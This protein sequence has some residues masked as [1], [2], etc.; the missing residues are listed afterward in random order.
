MFKWCRRFLKGLWP[1]ERRERR[2]SGS[3]GFR[4]LLLAADLRLKVLSI[5]QVPSLN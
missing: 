1:R 3:G 2:S 5:H 4:T